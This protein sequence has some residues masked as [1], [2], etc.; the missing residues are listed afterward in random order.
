MKYILSIFLMLIFVTEHYYPI[1]KS[2]AVSQDI[3]INKN[4]ICLSACDFPIESSDKNI[5][6][7]IWEIFKNELSWNPEITLDQGIAKTIAWWRKN[8]INNDYI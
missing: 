1:T 2:N 7:D 3:I 5:V 4:N 8:I 6:N